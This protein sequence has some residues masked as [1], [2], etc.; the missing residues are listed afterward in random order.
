VEFDAP[1][2]S[3]KRIVFFNNGMIRNWRIQRFFGNS[4]VRITI[5][6]LNAD[7]EQLDA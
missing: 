3:R 5:N 7:L 6:S 4:N 1:G 2:F